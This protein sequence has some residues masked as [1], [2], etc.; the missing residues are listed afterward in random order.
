MAAHSSALA[1]RI[2]W[3]E[4]PVGCSPWGHKEMDMTEA[5]EHTHVYPIGTPQGPIV[6]MCVCV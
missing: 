1:W 5:P 6:Y 2:P 4:E 3:A